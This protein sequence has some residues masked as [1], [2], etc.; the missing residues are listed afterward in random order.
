MATN[1]SMDIHFD[2]EAEVEVIRLNLIRETYVLT[3]EGVSFYGSADRI[4]EILLN[5]L[6]ALS[7]LR[8]K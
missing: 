3:I 8:K 2:G 7:D 5:G 6:N 1:Y 4:E